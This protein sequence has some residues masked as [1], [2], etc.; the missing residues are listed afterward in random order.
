MKSNCREYQ[1]AHSRIYE[2]MDTS[3]RM[4]IGPFC[5]LRNFVH[6]LPSYIAQNAENSEMNLLNTSSKVLLSTV[7]VKEGS[8]FVGFLPVNSVRTPKKIHQE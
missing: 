3:N 1:D 6:L 2:F 4:K 5:G 7:P 8:G